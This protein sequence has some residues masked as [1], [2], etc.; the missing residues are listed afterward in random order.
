MDS[1]PPSLQKQLLF[2]AVSAV[3]QAKVWIVGLA[4]AGAGVALLMAANS[5]RKYRAEVVVASQTESQ[6]S[7]LAGLVSQ[8][9]GLSAL[10]GLGLGQQSNVANSMAT[11]RGAKFTADFIKK[12]A[13]APGLFPDRWDKQQRRWIGNEPTDLE[14]VKAFDGG[15]IRTI[16]EDRRT[17]LINVRIQWNDPQEAV[18]ILDSMLAEVNDELRTKALEES[19]RSVDYLKVQLDQT[20]AVDLRQTINTLIA[21]N[22]KQAV[23]ANVRRDYAF[24]VVS[25]AVVPTSRDFVWPRRMLMAATGVVLG[26]LL[27]L[28]ASLSIALARRWRRDRSNQNG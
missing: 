25:P 14:L 15:G 18:R 13:L 6:A 4:L 27:G 24:Q 23:L 19:K 22:L 5:E 17:G 7:G 2:G 10:A 20:N 21:T 3:W 26:G 16:I 1:E 11:F 8:F 28:A 12:Q 9:G